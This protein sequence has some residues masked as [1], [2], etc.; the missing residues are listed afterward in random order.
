LRGI[1]YREQR[2]RSGADAI[3]GE[4]ITDPRPLIVGSLRAEVDAARLVVIYRRVDGAEAFRDTG[5]RIV[6]HDRSDES[7]EAALRVAAQKY[8]GRVQMTGSDMFQER[9]ARMATRLGVVHNTDL[10]AIVANERRRLDERWVEPRAPQPWI[11]TGDRR[12]GPTRTR[13]LER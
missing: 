8:G 11:N 4:E 10:Q 2:K 7:L 13:G 6:M 12:A 5:P 1:R 9:A 3:E